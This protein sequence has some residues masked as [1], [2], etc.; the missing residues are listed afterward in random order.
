MPLIQGKSKKAF[1][2]NVKTE[3]EHGHPQKQALAIAYSVMRK[4]GHK[5]S[6]GGE[7]MACGG[8][9]CKYAKGGEVGVHE[10]A[11][12]E[13]YPG[14][15]KAGQH[16]RSMDINKASKEKAKNEHYQVLGQMRSMPSPKLKGLGEGGKVYSIGPMK[17]T[18]QP[19]KRA[20]EA[21]AGGGAVDPTIGSSLGNSA[22]NFFEKMKHAKGGIVKD[23]GKTP[24]RSKEELMSERLPGSRSRQLMGEHEVESEMNID[25]L[26]EG[27]EVDDEL[28][29]ACADEFLKAVESKNKKEM[30]EA[31]KAIIESCK[32]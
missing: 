21:Y 20:L 31:L 24:Y 16:A 27:G 14:E 3:M 26:A 29:E 6:D 32:G 23:M 13:S 8:K 19:S 9:A 11:F 15:S 1:S 7:C 10:Q 28:M 17:D 4:A 5:M 25:H 22:S 18:R 30:L 12:E 2:E